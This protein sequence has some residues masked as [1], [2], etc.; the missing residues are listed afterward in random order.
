MDFGLMLSTLK[1][2][3]RSCELSLQVYY[4]G[5]HLTPE[6]GN[7]Y[8]EILNEFS[9]AKKID[10]TYE[11]NDKNSSAIFIGK[12]ILKLSNE[13]KKNQPDITLTL[14]DRAEMLGVAVT[15]VY[16]KIPTAHIHGGDK[17]GHIDE[18]IRHSITKLSNL[19]FAA[20]DDSAERIRKMGED[21]FRI[22]VTGAPGLD[23]IINEKV[24]EK[25]ELIK[26]LRLK[27]QSKFMLVIQHPVFNEDSKKHI[28]NIIRAV[29]NFKLPVVIIYP[30]ADAGGR[31]IT[32]VINKENTNSLFRIYSNIERKLFLSLEKHASVWVTNSSAGIIE[33]AS[34]HTPV[35]NVGTRQKDRLRTGNIID[36]NYEIKNIIS[37]INKSLYDQNYLDTIKNITNP[38]GDGQTGTK[39]L[40]I[41]ENIPINDILLNKQIAY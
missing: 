1:K 29:K 37:A 10:C 3:E 32:K 4:T 25:N 27:P 2:I 33:S 36:V 30:N 9:D 38:W 12:F 8:K 24:L 26:F 11:T 15:S 5:V 17:T 41:L 34:F 18:I 19:H 21:D 14:G 40:N 39:I 13:F 16:N 28:I 7:T 20:N 35:V 23:S 22:F 31:E 6:F